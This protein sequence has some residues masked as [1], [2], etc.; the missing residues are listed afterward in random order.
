MDGRQ[1]FY[2]IDVDLAFRKRK[3]SEPSAVCQDN[4]FCSTGVIEREQFV[5]ADAIEKRWH[6]QRFCIARDIPR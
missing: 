3:F 6:T 4:M 5:E 2:C 1:I